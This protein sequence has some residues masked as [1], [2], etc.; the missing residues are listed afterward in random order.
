[1]LRGNVAGLQAGTCNCD[2]NSIRTSEPARHRHCAGVKTTAPQSIQRALRM[3]NGHLRDECCEMHQPPP[4][5]VLQ[6]NNYNS[7]KLSFV[8]AVIL[9]FFRRFLLRLTEIKTEHTERKT[10]VRWIAAS[11]MN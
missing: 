3:R 10:L 6:Y 11:C 2:R 4:K 5:S 1:M 9:D 7:A 8:F